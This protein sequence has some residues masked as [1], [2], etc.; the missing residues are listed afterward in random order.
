MIAGIP[1]SD[2]QSRCQ[3]GVRVA[4]RHGSS[5]RPNCRAGAAP[6]L[7]TVD[8]TLGL[9]TM[10]TAAGALACQPEPVSLGV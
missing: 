4:A 5:R 7:G 1:E 9:A 6:G 10:A 2:W 8:A 3:V